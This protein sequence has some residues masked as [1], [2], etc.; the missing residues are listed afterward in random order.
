VYLLSFE[1]DLLSGQTA[2]VSPFP[3]FRLCLSINCPLVRL[4]AI[5]DHVLCC[6]QVVLE[7]L[8]FV[9][10]VARSILAAVLAVASGLRRKSMHNETV[11]GKPGTLPCSDPLGPI[12][13]DPSYGGENF[14]VPSWCSDPWTAIKTQDYCCEFVGDCSDPGFLKRNC[15]CYPKKKILFKV[16]KTCGGAWNQCGAEMCGMLEMNCKERGSQKACAMLEKNKQQNL[17]EPYVYDPKQGR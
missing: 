16:R 12:C 10:M 11:A 17:C 6:E 14:G 2:E 9:A 7:T 15:N 1:R 13:R 3:E 4:E 5:L 8:L